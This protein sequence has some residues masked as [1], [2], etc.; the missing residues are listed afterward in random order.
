MAQGT[1]SNS[2]RTTT[3]RAKSAAEQAQAASTGTTS[4]SGTV[5]EA[6]ASAEAAVAEAIKATPEPGTAVEPAE[7]VSALPA[8]GDHDRVAMLSVR[9]DG[10]ADQYDPEFVIGED[11]AKAAT[12][13]QFAEQAVSAAD[14]QVPASSSTVTI[15]GTADGEPDKVIPLT[16]D[17]TRSQTALQALHEDI[18]EAAVS[19]ADAA[20]EKFTRDR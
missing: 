11:A 7:V 18:V 16:T 14:A 15:V 20:V 3:G 5:A 8:G 17:A 10:S 2:S 9:A 12:R 4:D 1:S 6:P 13:R 19:A